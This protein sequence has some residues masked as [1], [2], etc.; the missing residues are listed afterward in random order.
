[1]S[2][3]SWMRSDR[4]GMS[5]GGFAHSGYAAVE[6]RCSSRVVMHGFRPV[7]KTQDFVLTKR[8]RADKLPA[9]LYFT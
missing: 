8:V 6:G 5:R 9:P 1:M 4:L 7:E 3:Q 2:Y